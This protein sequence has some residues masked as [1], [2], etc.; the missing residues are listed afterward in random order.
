MKIQKLLIFLISTFIFG[1][2]YYL[3]YHFDN[4][5]FIVLKNNEDVNLFDFL[6]FSLV[7]QTTVGYGGMKAVKNISKLANYIQ[8][9]VLSYMLLQ[10]M[11]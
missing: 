4:D 8:L 3:V 9:I 10:F 5:S 2:I 1:I 11:Y 6:H 7:T